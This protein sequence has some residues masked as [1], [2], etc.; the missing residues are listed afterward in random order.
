LQWKIPHDETFLIVLVH[1]QSCIV[2]IVVPDVEVVKYWAAENNI[3]GTLTVLCNHPEVKLLIMNDMIALGK[4][5][6]LKSFE[7]VSR[8][9]DGDFLD[10]TSLSPGQGHL[11]A[12]GSLLSAE[13]TLDT[14]VQVASAA[15]SQLLQA[16]A[17]RHVQIAGL[18]QD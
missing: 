13:S 7:Q 18:M 16:P 6:G 14:N 4:E 10:L 3:P 1:L 5:F 17:G 9:T 11:L 8:E 15:N 12:S 2:A